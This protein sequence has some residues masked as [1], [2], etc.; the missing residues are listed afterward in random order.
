MQ[1]EFEINYPT[2]ASYGLDED[3][4]DDLYDFLNGNLSPE[5]SANRMAITY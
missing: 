4:A 5:T 1:T 3:G 2:L